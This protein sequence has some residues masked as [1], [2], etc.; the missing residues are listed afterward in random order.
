MI[1]MWI[2]ASPLIH[3]CPCS[4]PPLLTRLFAPCPIHSQQP[5]SKP[6]K[7][8]QHNGRGCKYSP[9]RKYLFILCTIISMVTWNIPRNYTS[10]LTGPRTL[11]RLHSPVCLSSPLPL[12][13]TGEQPSTYENQFSQL[14]TA[15]NIYIGFYYFFVGEQSIEVDKFRTW[16][17]PQTFRLSC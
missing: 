16:Y 4:F 9:S 2:G 12:A 10:S 13:S 15:L 14:K 6:I 1:F 17:I 8:M 5:Y 7:R 3:T 11:G